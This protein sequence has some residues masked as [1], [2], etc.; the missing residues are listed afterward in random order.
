VELRRL[1]YFARLAELGS[2]RRAAEALGIF[3]N[4]ERA[5]QLAADTY[6]EDLH[7][8][9]AAD[10]LGM[11]EAWVSEHVPRGDGSTRPDTVPVADLLICKA[12]ALTRQIRLGP[13]VR[14]VSFYQR[15]LNPD[16]AGE[17]ESVQYWR[18]G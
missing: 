7:E 8:I 17:L 5:N 6:D 11:K 1:E 4:G 14:P 12:A 3:S 15:D 16:R 9:V 2:F 18:R 13:A 10:K